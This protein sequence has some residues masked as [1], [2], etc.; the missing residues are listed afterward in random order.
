MP[1]AAAVMPPVNAVQGKHKKS[2]Q[3]APPEFK[4]K[5]MAVLESLGHAESRSAKLAQP[6]FLSLLA[7][8]NSCGIHFA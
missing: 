3:R 4:D 8:F 5:V 2:R 7:A 6:D 1:S